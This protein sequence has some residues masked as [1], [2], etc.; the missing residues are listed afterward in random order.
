[1]K[2]TVV[3]LGYIGLP[4]AAQIASKGIR[5][6]GYDVNPEVVSTINRGKI[7]I[8]EN[9][10]EQLVKQ[11]VANGNLTAHASPQPADVFII[12]VPTPFHADKVPDLTYIKAAAE[13]IAPHL[14]PGNLII[15]ESTS[16][17]GT[18]ELLSQWILESRKDLTFNPEASNAIY[19][20]YCPERVLP[21]KILY[22]L[23]NNNR[24]IGGINAQ[25]SDKAKDFYYFF[26]KGELTLTNCRTAEMA[27]LTENTF[28][29]V[30]IALAN[31]LAD[32]CED[33]NVD[34]WELISITN[35]HPRVNVLNPGIG[36]G[37]HCIAVDPWFII[38]TSNVNCSLM[39]QAR[40]INM[41]KPGH[42]SNKI[43]ATAA[44]INAQRIA[45]FGLSY[46]PDIDDLRE[47]PA[48]E[49]VESLG[50]KYQGQIDLVEP[51]IT[52]LPGHLSIYG[53]MRLQN[54]ATALENAD[55]VV[56]LVAHS[57]FKMVINQINH[58]PILDFVGMLPHNRE[59]AS[60]HALAQLETV[61][62]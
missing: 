40:V 47:S 14:L 45:C 19:L 61:N 34:V 36:V 42:V 8:V 22:E 26:V 11:V 6:Q 7:H 41:G 35:K 20:A 21:G 56:V 44:Q 46:K 58:K 5:V 62:S 59:L 51:H 27:K 29:D 12:A 32:V 52:K 43:L 28:R 16:P 53:N 24:V 57:E 1:M 30:N 38:K 13:A 18:T 3:G 33:F 50:L 54:M 2:V 37:G 17:V 55:L 31:E 48:I 15:L 49:V 25:S 39:T 60:K 4:T 23:V 10:L 9:D